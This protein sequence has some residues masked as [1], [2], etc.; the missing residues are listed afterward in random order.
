MMI[1]F[2]LSSRR[3]HTSCELV[4]GVQTCALPISIA[5][6]CLRRAGRG[7]RGRSGRLSGDR[8]G[9]AQSDQARYQRETEPGRERAAAYAHDRHLI[10]AKRIAVSL[11]E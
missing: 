1:E 11:H 5:E 9:T 2:F 8:A 10:L 6:G 4:T 7:Y 3:R